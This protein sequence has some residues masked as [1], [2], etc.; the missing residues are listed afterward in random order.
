[1][2][3]KRSCLACIK[4]ETDKGEPCEWCDA[5]GYIYEYDA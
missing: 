3:R 2:K 5:T 1:M 4:G